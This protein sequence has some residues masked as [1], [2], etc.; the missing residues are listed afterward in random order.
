MSDLVL[1]NYFRSSTSYRVRLALHYKEIPFTSVPIH[2]LEDGG[3]QHKSSYRKLNPSGEVP[4][5]VHGQ[6]VIGQSMAIIQYLDEVFPQ[7][8]LFPEDPFAKAQVIQICEIIN[9]GHALHNLKV[10]QKLQSDYSFTEQQKS[11]WIQHWLG[12]ILTSC[13]A[14]VEKTSGQFSFQ[15]QITAADLFIVPALFTARRFSVET[16][17]LKKLN[18]IDQ[19]IQMLEFAKKSH[20]G[21]QVDTPADFK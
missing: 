2:L 21:Q 7:K 19:K 18:E 13:E 15:E 12:Q 20:P 11:Q 14:L 9:C 3:Q 16:S 8:P 1:Y 17:Q 10:L 6:K 4:T 5:L